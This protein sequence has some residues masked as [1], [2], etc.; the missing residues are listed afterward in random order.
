MIVLIG[1]EALLRRGSILL[2][3]SNIVGLLA[4]WLEALLAG[5]GVLTLLLHVVPL[6]DGVNVPALWPTADQKPQEHQTTD[7]DENL[8]Q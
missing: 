4:I 6:L 8:L 1:W 5:H 3:L 7:A 2:I